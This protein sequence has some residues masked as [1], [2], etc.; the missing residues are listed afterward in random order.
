MMN[1]H[2]KNL[3]IFEACSPP[4]KQQLYYTT[5]EQQKSDLH[6]SSA[7]YYSFCH[8]PCVPYLTQD[9]PM[10]DELSD[11]ILQNDA[12]SNLGYQRL[13]QEIFLSVMKINPP[14]FFSLRPTILKLKND[15]IFELIRNHP[16]PLCL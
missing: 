15:V 4:P 7:A 1:F 16:R 13:G 2:E 8:C 9:R 11:D 5:V 12:F 10:P 3:I 6:T 14:N